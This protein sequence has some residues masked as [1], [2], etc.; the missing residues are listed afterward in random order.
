[1]NTTLLMAQQEGG[2]PMGS[3][4]MMGLIFL[5]FYFFMIRPQN[6]KAKETKKFRE[7]IKKGDKIV[8]LGGIHGKVVQANDKT[9][10]IESEGSR[11]KIERSAV[12]YEY[13]TGQGNDAAAGNEIEKKS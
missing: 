10:I 6:K 5:I 13:T 1:M 9:L 2:N 8:T 4:I 11:L 12:S 3:I 7:S